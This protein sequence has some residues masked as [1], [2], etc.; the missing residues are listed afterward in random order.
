MARRMGKGDA[1]VMLDMQNDFFP[2]GPMEVAGAEEVVP[3]LN[4]WIREARDT[5]ALL[6]AVRDW[7]TVDHVSF[8][9]EGG[10]WPPHCVQDTPGSF[11]HP[12]LRLPYNLVV[13]S[14]GCAFD[15]DAHSAFDGTGLESFLRKRGIE[16]LWIGGLNEETSVRRTVEDACRLGFETHVIVAATRPLEPAAA[17]GV[18]AALSNR[19]AVL[20]Q[21]RNR[22]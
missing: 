4:D 11:F 20:E 13:V 19:G 10:P 3:V 9:S 6:I 8:E 7:H 18:L 5:E 1:L 2:G 12:S 14:K 15:T 16:R 17:E 21:P 22:A